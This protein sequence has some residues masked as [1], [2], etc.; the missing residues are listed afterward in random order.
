MKFRKVTPSPIQFF[1]RK[2]Q[3]LVFSWLQ[4]VLNF[5][6]RV[7]M[8]YYQASPLKSY[9]EFVGDWSK[10]HGVENAIPALAG[11]A[12]S[13]AAS[14]VDVELDVAETA[15]RDARPFIQKTCSPF[16]FFTRYMYNM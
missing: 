8:S 7:V 14:P 13:G 9:S 6:R 10:E 11:A 1:D 3:Y 15:D 2:T 16:S 4:R 12:D 5:V